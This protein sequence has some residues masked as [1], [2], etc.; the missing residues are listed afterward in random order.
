MA[1]PLGSHDDVSTTRPAPWWRRALPPVLAAGLV[2]VLGV[3]LLRPARSV[4]PGGALVSRPAPDFTLQSLSGERVTLSGYRG[5]PV[6]LNFW[7]SWCGPCRQEAPLFHDLAARTDGDVAVVGVLFQETNEANA[8]AFVRANGLTYPNLSDP[9]ADT[10][11]R[12]AVSG[13]PQTVFIDRSGVVQFVDRGGLN[14]ERLN[15]GLAR[16]GVPKL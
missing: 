9:G 16:I 10:G 2:A 4:P 13:I 7:A 3:S 12:Y 8:R 14:R 6:V 15:V 11:I 1:V 5:R